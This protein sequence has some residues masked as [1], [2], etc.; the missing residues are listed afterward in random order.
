MPV[1]I[2]I[3]DD[4]PVFVAAVRQFLDFLPGAEVV[5]NAAN[6]QQALDSGQ[7]LEPDL[8]LIDVAIP[9]MP[10][11][12]LAGRMRDW[13]RPPA[14]ML[15]SVQDAS[16]YVAPARQIGALALSCKS[17]FVIEL[18]PAIEALV[19]RSHPQHLATPRCLHPEAG[20]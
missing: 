8:V 1:R 15:L 20:P 4:N 14:T 3:V 11:L 19:A 12:A 18:L 10:G 6:A 16:A 7:L 9:G 13:A 2:L 5:G 17:D